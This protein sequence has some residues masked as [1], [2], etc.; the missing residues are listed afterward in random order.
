MKEVRQLQFYVIRP[1]NEVPYKTVFLQVYMLLCVIKVLVFSTLC[2]FVKYA[3]HF[4]FRPVPVAARSKVL[5][6][7]R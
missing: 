5:V 6:C 4:E 2:A 7:G 3:Y 1:Y